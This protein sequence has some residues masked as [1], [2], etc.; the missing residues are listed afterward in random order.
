MDNQQQILQQQLLLEGLNIELL[1]DFPRSH[2]EINDLKE[3]VLELHNYTLEEHAKILNCKV[4]TISKLAKLVYNQYE[5]L[6]IPIGFKKVEIKTQIPYAVNRNGVV[7]N[8]KTR[9][10]LSCSISKKG[11]IISPILKYNENGDRIKNYPLHRIVAYT[12]LLNPMNYKQVNHID[13]NKNN[14]NIE[15][16]EWC[17]N[18]YNMQHSI[19]TVLRN[20]ENFS[21]GSRQGNSILKEEQVENI[22]KEY[23]EK[24]CTK[25]SF[26]TKKAIELGVSI[27]CISLITSGI[28]WKHI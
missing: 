3:R 28:N 9:R 26:D 12:Y 4:S 2:F 7:I 1:N 18:D 15:N 6:P 24:T 13:G 5:K 22:K 27:S 14:N 10:I 21:R 11:Y 23:L 8:L 17:D 25:L 16:L 20:R 19:D